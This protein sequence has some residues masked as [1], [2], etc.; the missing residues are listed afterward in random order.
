MRTTVVSALGVLTAIALLSFFY[1]GGAGTVTSSSQP[2]PASAAPSAG[3]PA[4][5]ETATFG[6]GCFWCTEAV[7]QQLKGVH[8]VV[9]G[10][11]GGHVP[12]PTYEQVCTGQTGHAEGIEIHFDPAVISYRELLE[13][14]WLTHDPTTLNR[15]G[16][17]VG[18]QY[19]SAVF[20]HSPEQQQAAE[21]LKQQL[22]DSNAFG[23]PVVTEI[24]AASKFYSAEQYHQ[25]YFNDNQRQPY[26]AR[27]IR[28]K[29][30]KVREVFKEKVQ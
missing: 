22:N 14:F 13:A 26:C 27:I 29:V 2:Q 20:F 30:D 16:A 10:Y 4:K 15:Q 11:I 25:N 3:A 12:N 5:L 24:T 28:P 17:D 1:S 9:S 6:A 19:R 18:T 7:F 23:K 8:R 21:N